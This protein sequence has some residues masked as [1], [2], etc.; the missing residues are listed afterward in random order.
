MAWLERRGKKWLVVWREEGVKHSEIRDTRD[1]ARVLKADIEKRQLQGNW[2][3]AEDRKQ[4]FGVYAL[5]QVQS[6][7]RIRRV[8]KQGYVRAIRLHLEP[9]LGK[10]LMGD[11]QPARVRAALA[12]IYEET[13][14][15]TTDLC[16]KLLSRVFRQAMT[17]G[18]LT[19]DPLAGYR[20][21]RVTRRPIQILTDHEVNAIANA[22]QPRF[23]AMVLLSAW[24]GFRIGELGS[25]CRSDIDF[26]RNTISIH[27]AVSVSIGK[28]EIGPP[29][30]ESSRRTVSM[31]SWVMTEL[32]QHLLEFP[33]EYVFSLPRGGIVTHQT[34]HDHWV[35]GWRTL[36]AEE[37]YSRFH[38][39][40]HTAVSILIR[41]GAH[42]KLIQSRM[43]HSSITQT[44]DTYGHLFPTADADL[45]AG[46]E[47]FKPQEGKVIEL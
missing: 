39:L 33:G 35:A 23:R 14:P 21:P 10:V 22:V 29:K 15:W 9:R 3:A 31:P 45:A 32:K 28:I 27:R 19:R 7:V 18:I 11:I 42:P 13:S 38:D 1:E 34:L 6:D 20:A 25:L 37:P 5:N 24:G 4:P 44:L 36:N 17:D 16:H 46:L 2:A 47:Q 43:G 8:T 30:T 41:Q 26:S 12:A 40:R